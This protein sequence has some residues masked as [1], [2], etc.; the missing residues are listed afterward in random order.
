LRFQHPSIADLEFEIPD[1]WLETS[2]ALAFRP[3]TSAY[4]ADSN[5]EWPT[6]VA[7][8]DEIEPPARDVGVIGLHKDRAVSLIQAIVEARPLPPIEAHK[9]PSA[10]ARRLTIRDGYHRYYISIALGFTHVPVSIRPYFDID[11]M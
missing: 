5:E 8:I 6:S 9:E 1:A 4:A 11:S 2:N 7:L 10:T 3:Q